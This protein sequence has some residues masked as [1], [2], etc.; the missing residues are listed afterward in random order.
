MFH[1]LYVFRETLSRLKFK[2]LYAQFHNISPVS[3]GKSLAANQNLV[4]IR[5]YASSYAK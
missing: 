4:T 5:I 2:F 3:L 1:L